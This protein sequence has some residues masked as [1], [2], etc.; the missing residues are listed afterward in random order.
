MGEK[1]K[2]VRE[3]EDEERK[4][5]REEEKLVLDMHQFFLPPIFSACSANFFILKLRLRLL[6]RKMVSRKMISVFY[7]VY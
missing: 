4:V 3:G 6:R 5:K 2:N 7:G 1:K